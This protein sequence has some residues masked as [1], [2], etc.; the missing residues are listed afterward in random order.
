[1]KMLT[2]ISLSLITA[3]AGLAS[4]PAASADP[5]GRAWH[6]RGH[7]YRPVFVRNHIIVP[8]APAIVYGEPYYYPPVPIYYTP[9][10]P[11]YS[12]SPAIT[13]GV[14]IPPIVIPLR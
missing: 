7:H 14:A 6:D 11:V 5:G 13:I 4:V 12:R 10:P 9:F 8:R 3:V 2:R 1:M